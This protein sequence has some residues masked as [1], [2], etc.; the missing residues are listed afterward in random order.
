MTSLCSNPTLT[1]KHQFDFHWYWLII[2]LKYFAVLYKNL[3]IPFCHN[4]LIQQEREEF[5]PVFS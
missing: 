4:L 1:G 3:S 2:L 5:I